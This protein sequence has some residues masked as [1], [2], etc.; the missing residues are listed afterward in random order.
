MIGRRGLRVFT[1]MTSRAKLFGHSIHP[2]LV[3]FPVGL[4]STAVVFDVVYLIN[5]RPG[6]TVAS[7]Y[8]IAAGVIGGALAAPFGWIDWFKIPANTRAKRLGLVHGIANA[9]VLVLFAISWWL[10]AD[11]GSWTPTVPALVCSFV[12]V[13]VAGAAAWM[14]GE[15][16]DRL[17]IGIDEGAN[18]D[19]PSSLTHKQAA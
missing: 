3:P 11:A 16:V 9:V 13:A 15:L 7:A 2:M 6:F 4:L 5:D 12:G 8:A 1:T 19:A 14:G 17:A 10:R 18:P